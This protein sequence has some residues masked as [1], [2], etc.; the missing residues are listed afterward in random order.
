MTNAELSE[1][2]LIVVGLSRNEISRSRG[3]CELEVG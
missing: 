1:K 3:S 2:P